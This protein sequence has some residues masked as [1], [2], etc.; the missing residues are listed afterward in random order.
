[1]KARPFLSNLD[2][3]A[4]CGRHHYL[5]RN[6]LANRSEGYE[7]R[8]WLNLT[9]GLRD[10]PLNVRMSG[11]GTMKPGPLESQRQ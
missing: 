5:M 3:V 1:M 2:R 11:E 8:F 6:T 10:T 7:K 4:F 9:A